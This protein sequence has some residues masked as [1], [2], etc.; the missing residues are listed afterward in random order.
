MSEVYKLDK[1][2]NEFSWNKATVSSCESRQNKL[3]EPLS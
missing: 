1:A 3:I 2:G